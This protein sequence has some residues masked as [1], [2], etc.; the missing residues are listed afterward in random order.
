MLLEMA[1]NGQL[2]GAD[3]TL[4]PQPHS[5][6]LI[7]LCWGEAQLVYSQS[8]FVFPSGGGMGLRSILF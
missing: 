8:P 3:S 4:A 2:R 6:G 7:F 5:V 1:R